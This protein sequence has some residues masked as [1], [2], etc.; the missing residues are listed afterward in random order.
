MA[1]VLDALAPYVKKLITDMA[2][3]EVSMLLGISGEITKL[4]A[5]MEDLRA[6]VSDADRRRIT[7]QNVQRW[8]S[9]LKDAICTM[10]PTSWSFVSSRPMSAGNWKKVAAAGSRIL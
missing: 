2:Q 4:D 8:V 6:F 1:A 3:E 7:D 9:K 5:R 10:P